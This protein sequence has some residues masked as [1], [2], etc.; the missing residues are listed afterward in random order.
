M[1]N[2]VFYIPDSTVD[3]FSIIDP[4]IHL[5]E[6]SFQSLSQKLY[7]RPETTAIPRA[8]K[9]NQHQLVDYFLKFHL[10]VINP[11][12]Y[13]WWNDYNQLCKCWLPTMADPS[14]ALRYGVVAFSALVYS[15]KI[16]HTARQFAFFYYANSLKE[17]RQLLD[18]STE[19]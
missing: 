19:L 11:S 12:H 14:I 6:R 9:S 3:P 4:F 10:D 13:F 1:L 17:L 16:D 8:P 18:G 7:F 5:E 2:S 15:M